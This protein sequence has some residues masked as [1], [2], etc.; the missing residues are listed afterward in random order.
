MDNE[1]EKGAATD[2]FK[3]VLRGNVAGERKEVEKIGL[4]PQMVL[5][6]NWQ[7]GRLQRTYADLL[8]NKK[9]KATAEFFMNDLYGANDFSQRD[10]DAE[11][12]YN[13]MRKYFPKRIL[14]TMGKAIQLNKLTKILDEKLLDI[15]IHQLG[16]TDELTEADYVK[17]YRLCDNQAVRVRQIDTVLEVGKGVETLTRIPMTGML[18][19]G[20]RRPAQ[21]GGWTELQDFLERGF[22]AFKQ[23]KG[24]EP[25]LDL[26]GKREHQILGQIFSGAENPFDVG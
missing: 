12:V 6:K 11:N 24:A 14:A 16:M 1:E 18:L 23:M 5:L 21:R 13:T 7:V 17:A 15:L 22:T 25:F 4:T 3:Q 9:Y 10:A 19:R 20:A 2:L 8:D 26:V